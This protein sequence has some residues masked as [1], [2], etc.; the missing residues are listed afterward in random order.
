MEAALLA[1]LRA[2]GTL[3]GARVNWDLRP[4]NDPL[5]AVVLSIVSDARPLHLKGP[6]A[7]RRTRVNA[8]CW[9]ASALEATRLAIQVIGAA[10]EPATVQGVRFGVTRTDGGQSFVET[11]DGQTIFRRSIDLLVWH[12]GE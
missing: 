7:R 6:E 3:A 9:G 11:Q 1:R 12:E 2:A 4:Q 8:D 5:P 10:R